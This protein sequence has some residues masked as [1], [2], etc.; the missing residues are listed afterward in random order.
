[1]S[2]LRTIFNGMYQ[3][4]NKLTPQTVVDEARPVDSPLHP[5]FEWDDNVAAHH[6]RLEQARHLIKSV[7]WRYAEPSEAG[8]TPKTVRAFCSVLTDEGHHF[9]PTPVVADDPMLRKIVLQDMQR[10]W[11]QLFKRYKQFREF[12]EMVRG[13]LEG[14]DE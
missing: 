6:W 9:V 3:R 11:R 12:L 7:K 14:L 10:E 5:Y 1:M 13:D 2:D 8:E 4:D